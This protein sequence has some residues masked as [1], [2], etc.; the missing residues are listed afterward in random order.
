MNMVSILYFS[1][2]L[3]IITC[4]GATNIIVNG[5][6]FNK[7]R[8]FCNNVHPLLGKLFSCM[9]CTATWVGFI[10]S[11]LFIIL[12]IHTPW[13]SIAGNYPILV[14]ILSGFLSSGSVWL[15]H[16]LQEYFDKSK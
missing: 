15:L 3:F 4:Y 13:N 10:I 11:G 5:S 1:L 16:T 7:F 2:I 6:I 9:R 12:G 8:E 14:V